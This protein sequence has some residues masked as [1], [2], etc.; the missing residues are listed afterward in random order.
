LYLPLPSLPQQPVT[1]MY[2]LLLLLLP[3]AIH[4]EACQH[5]AALRLQLCNRQH[6]EEAAEAA[7]RK[8]ELAAMAA[9][10]RQQH[11]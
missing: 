8:A 9:A 2:L 10:R 7:R 11:T 4:R 3:Q 5:I 6:E 1:S